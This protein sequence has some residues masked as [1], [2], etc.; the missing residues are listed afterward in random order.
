[1]QAYRYSGETWLLS[2]PTESEHTLRHSPFSPGITR[3]MRVS[4]QTVRDP[5]DESA[6]S[7]REFCT[8]RRVL[9]RRKLSR[10]VIP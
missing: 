4:N 8:N 2:Q 10:A 7:Y 6:G 9:T 1:M 3:E 5:P